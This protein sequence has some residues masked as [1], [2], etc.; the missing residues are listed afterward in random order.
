MLVSAL[1]AGTP[2]CHFKA[3]VSSCVNVHEARGQKLIF[4]ISN[5]HTFYLKE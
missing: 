5:I 3:L 4:E 1:W 2:L